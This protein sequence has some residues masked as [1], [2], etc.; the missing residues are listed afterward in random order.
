MAGAFASSASASSHTVQNMVDDASAGDTVSVPAG[1]YPETVT[2]DKALTLVGP[3][4]GLHPEYDSRGPEATLEGFRIGADDVSLDGFRVADGTKGVA[5]VGSGSTWS[6]ISVT[7]TD[8]DSLSEWPVLHGFGSGGGVGTKDW[9]VS[10]SRIANITGDNITGIVL[11]NVDGVTLE[12]NHVEHATSGVSGRRG[13]NLD[14]CSDVT[15]TDCHVDMGLR[16]PSNS[17]A[18]F[19][20]ARYSLQLSMSDQ[21]VSDVHVC[22]NTFMGGYDCVVTLG[23]GDISDVELVNNTLTDNVIGVRPQAGTNSSTGSVSRFTI[24]RNDIADQVYGIFVDDGGSSGDPYTDFAANLND[25]SGNDLGLLVQSGA[26]VTD[27]IDA[28]R[29]WWGDRSGADGNVADPDELASTKPWLRNEQAAG[30]V[31]GKG[32][33]DD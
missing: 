26:N 28:E 31:P 22:N 25:L 33:L 20:A 29:N 9:T 11:F 32:C 6:S 21:S 19:N 24:Q 7:H 15:M 10:Q 4:A 30:T 14:G 13:H 5:S 17:L 23:N 27:G 2:V 3:N 8:F 18:S 16:S 1:T 12:R